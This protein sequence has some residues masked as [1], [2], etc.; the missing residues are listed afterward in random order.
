MADN[1]SDTIMYTISTNIPPAFSHAIKLQYKPDTPFISYME[2]AKEQDPVHFSFN[3]KDYPGM[4]FFVTE[5]NGRPA[6]ND[7]EIYWRLSN[8]SPL[9][10]GVSYH[11]PE[12]G[13]HLTFELVQGYPEKKN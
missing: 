11:I 1:A 12:K 8:Q 13:E 10:V 7:Q 9:S 5:I 3:G 6:I 4:G 2:R